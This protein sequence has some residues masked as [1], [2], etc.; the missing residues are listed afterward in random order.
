MNWD[1]RFALRSLGRHKGLSAVIVLTLALAIGANTAIFSLADAMLLRA[2]PVRDSGSLL[3]FA[4]RARKAPHFDSSVVYGDCVSSDLAGAPTGCSYSY[5]F[6]VDLQ[7]HAGNVAQ[8]AGYRGF[9]G[10]NLTGNGPATPTTVEP[11]S[12][13]YFGVLGLRPSAGRLLAPSDD[14]AT[15]P[16][17]VVLSYAYWQSHFGG[18]TAVVGRRV[19]L[20]QVPVT[21][22][23]VAPRGFGGLRPGSAS[24]AWFTLHALP[25][26]ESEPDPDLL[27][28]SDSSWLVLIGRL[29]PGVSRSRAQA[30]IGGL[31]RDFML[32]GPKPLLHAADSPRMDIESAQ[33]ALQGA[34]ATFSQP[35]TVLLWA[36]GAILLLACANIAGLLLGRA[37]ARR[38]EF[39]LR[40]ALGGGRGRILRQLLTE[41]L[42]LA[43]MGGALGLALAYLAS[44]ALAAAIMASRPWLHWGAPLSLP[45]L[46]FALGVTVAT[47]ILFGL[48]PGLSASRLDLAGALK[49]GEGTTARRRGAVG[50]TLVVAQIA[51]AVVILSGAGLLVRSL[52][53]LR[54]VNPGF[55]TSHL[56]LFSVEPDSAGFKGAAALQLYGQLRERVGALPGVRSVSYSDCAM[57]AGCME[58]GGAKIGTDPKAPVRDADLLRIGPGYFSTLGM[59]LLAGRSFNARDFALKPSPPEAAI[60]NQTFVRAYLHGEALGQRLGD[61]QVIVGVV[62]DTH[63]WKLSRKIQPMLYRPATESYSATFA[64]RTGA[65]PMALL[66]AVRRVVASLAPNMPVVQPT[67]QSASIGQ[68]LF[69][70]RI[71]AEL[72]ACAGGLALLLAAIGLY[73][74]L[75]E[76]VGQRTREIGIR[77]ALGAQRRRVLRMVAGRGALMTAIGLAL[78][79][80][81]AWALTRYLRSL[82]F[83]VQ[84]G[85]PATLAMVAVV[86]LAVALAACILPARRAARVDPLIALR[87]D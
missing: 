70:Q 19:A 71:L 28:D 20:N 18:S 21:I 60:V 84:P 64:V 44:H 67:T 81:G 56:L 63:Y 23:G 37:H 12:G 50:G 16:V 46:G 66:P 68:L 45:V 22:V 72:S 39:A 73:G 51:L 77:M 48:A 36:A 2:L 1:L 41:S 14:T 13:N 30:E 24:D 86:L 49:T 35:L 27:L 87:Q 83:G 58:A 85:D 80:G 40:R 79:A 31:L 34:R 25:R 10:F 32:A 15:A 47:G 26:I 42:L 43:A 11:V 75:A 9:E 5:P 54:S 33:I 57:L 38:R 4:W 82:L 76:E 59:R 61:K 6:L 53:D 78:G 7:Q 74:L 3:L 65:S 69:Q 29:R 52:E 17:R 62:S 55:N 8:V